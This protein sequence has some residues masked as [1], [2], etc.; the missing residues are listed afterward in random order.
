MR[1]AQLSGTNDYSAW[2]YCRGLCPSIFGSA[3]ACA[4]FAVT[5]CEILHRA[6]LCLLCKLE[7]MNPQGQLNQSINFSSTSRPSSSL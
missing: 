1:D 5:F 2:R 3:T 4:N 6:S 7:C